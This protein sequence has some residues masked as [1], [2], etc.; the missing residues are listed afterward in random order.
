MFHAWKIRL[1][2]WKLKGSFNPF[3]EPVRRRTSKGW[4]RK[5]DEEDLMLNSSCREFVQSSR[6][7]DELLN[8]NCVCVWFFESV[9]SSGSVKRR[10]FWDP[11]EYFR[12]RLY[13]ASDG[14]W[15]RSFRERGCLG[16]DVRLIELWCFCKKQYFPRENMAEI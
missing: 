16:C 1:I 8:G 13:D 12:R 14:L 5:A 4:S 9:G 10:H 2:G 6:S 15:W 3:E 11:F 7:A